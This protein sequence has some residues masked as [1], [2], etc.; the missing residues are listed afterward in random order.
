MITAK[1]SLKMRDCS[2]E[3]PNE[4]RGSAKPCSSNVSWSEEQLQKKTCTCEFSL[5]ETLVRSFISSH[6][7]LWQM[8]TCPHTYD[9]LEICAFT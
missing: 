7:L 9:Q 6:H 1:D 4:L 5:I 8:L 2:A 3:H